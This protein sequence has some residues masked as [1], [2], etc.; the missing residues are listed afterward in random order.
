MNVGDVIK[1]VILHV[2][3]LGKPVILGNWKTDI[4]T[5][6]ALAVREENCVA[7]Y[8][9]DNCWKSDH[10]MSEMLFIK[11]YDCKLVERQCS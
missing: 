10:K 5:G 3:T 9:Y 6:F 11:F 1:W 8:V 7:V 4:F 2:K